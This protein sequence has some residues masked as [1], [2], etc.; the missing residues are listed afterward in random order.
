MGVGRAEH[1]YQSSGVGAIE[2]VDGDRGLDVL[3][4]GGGVGAHGGPGECPLGSRSS[5]GSESLS[6]QHGGEGRE[7]RQM[8][9]IEGW[10]FSE[11]HSLCFFSK[12]WQDSTHRPGPIGGSVAWGKQSATDAQAPL[13][14]LG[15]S[16]YVSPSG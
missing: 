10:W 3:G 1:S 12:G 4:G 15:T 5:Q 6:R 14:Y 16:S 11:V 8:C 7:G 2:A 9:G 13:W